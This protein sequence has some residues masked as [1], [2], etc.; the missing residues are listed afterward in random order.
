MGVET[1]EEAYYASPRHQVEITK[2]FYIGEYPVTGVME[3]DDG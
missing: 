2:E 1:K 3:K